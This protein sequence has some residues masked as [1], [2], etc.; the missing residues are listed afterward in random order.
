MTTFVRGFWIEKNRRGD[1][2]DWEEGVKPSDTDDTFWVKARKE[3][4]ICEECGGSR[5]SANSSCLC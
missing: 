3:D 4:Y 5:L 2:I 1:V